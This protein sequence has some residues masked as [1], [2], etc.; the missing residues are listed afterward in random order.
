[1]AGGYHAAGVEPLLTRSQRRIF[2]SPV[3]WL[4]L[5]LFSENLYSRVGS[6]ADTQTGKCLNVGVST[7]VVTANAPGRYRLGFSFDRG[8]ECA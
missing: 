3:Q 4:H 2:L 5:R 8:D 1:M 6:R 7:P